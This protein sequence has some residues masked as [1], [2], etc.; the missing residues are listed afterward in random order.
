VPFSEAS[1][2]EIF[3]EVESNID[4]TQL[5]ILV[6]EDNLLNQEIVSMMLEDHGIE[7]DVVADGEQAVNAVR[8]QQPDLVL[9]DVQMPVMDGLQATKLIL[10]EFP[11]LPV[12]ALTAIVM[13]D[14]IE[15]YERS[16]FTA[17][18]G[19]PFEEQALLSLISKVAMDASVS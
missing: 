5:K 8:E 16:G 14:D 13:K 9:M 7:C 12:V 6:A 2:T 10:S 17:H 3:T 4:L 11:D 15:L 19:K 1:E 18:V